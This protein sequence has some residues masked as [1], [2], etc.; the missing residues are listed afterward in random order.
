MKTAHTAALEALG[1]LLSQRRL[2]ADLV[3][4]VVVGDG[5]L[6]RLG[7]GLGSRFAQQFRRQV[8]AR[9]RRENAVFDARRE[10]IRPL[11]HG[12]GGDANCIRGGRDGAA[13]Q[14][15]GLCFE[16]AQS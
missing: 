15:N 4:V 14:F 2:R 9:Q 16:H 12:R 8:L 1:P 11:S 5:H 7:F 10:L 3:L 13:E 6:G